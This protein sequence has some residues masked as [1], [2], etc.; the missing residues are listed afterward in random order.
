MPLGRIP[1]LDGIRAVSFM[2][3]FA[4]HAQI[5]NLVPGGLLRGDLGVTIFFFL[6][7]FIITT[8]LRSE[9]EK[10]GSVN[11][12]HFWLRRAL[13][14]LPPLFVV[15]LASVLITLALYP[16]GTMRGTGVVSELLFYSNYWGIYHIPDYEPRGMDV[17]WSLAVEE[18]FYLLFPLL[19]V[20][21]QK[22]RLPPQRQ[23][24][25]LWGI[26]AAILAWRCVLVMSMHATLPRIYYATD[27]RVDSILFGCALAVWNN[28]VLD[29]PTL[30]K[31]IRESDRWLYVLLPAALGLLLACLAY[32]NPVFMKTWYF[33]VQ[34]V[35]LTLMFM[36]AVRYHQAPPFRF[37]NYRPVVYIGILSYSL[38]L[39]HNVLLHANW[40]L[41]PHAHMWQ[42]IAI[43]LAGSLIAAWLIH[44]AV[45]K[46]CARQRARLAHQGIQ[47]APSSKE[48]VLNESA[49]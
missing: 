24:L 11:I 2:L 39:V 33:S 15:V 19:Y 14:I 23:A 38:Y 36:C 26:C 32:H 41:W 3:V 31:L 20:S 6:S 9:F 10:H 35:A 46:P 28:P 17:V 47:G 43:A 37:L 12:T 7:G 1:S 21:M 34:G 13:R 4:V 30:E 42:R 40:Q 18:H 5:G 16:P 8:L 25:L 44:Q 48:A 22:W 29:K 49:T 45:D 27:T